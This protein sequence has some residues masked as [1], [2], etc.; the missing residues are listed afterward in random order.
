MS[1]AA[2]EIWVA[3]GRGTLAAVFFAGFMLLFTRVGRWLPLGVGSIGE[4]L[5]SFVILIIYFTIF[6]FISIAMASVA[7]RLGLPSLTGANHPER[8]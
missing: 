5:L 6:G 7:R 8:E 2:R 4:A 3:L 1:P